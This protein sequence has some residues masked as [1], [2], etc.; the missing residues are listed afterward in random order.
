MDTDDDLFDLEKLRLPEALMVEG[1]AA[2]KARRRRQQFVKF[3]CSWVER[4]QAAR[5]IGSYRLALHLLHRHW[6]ADGKPVRASNVAVAWVGLSRGEK[7][8][9]LEELER[10]G[11]IRVERRPRQAPLVTVLVS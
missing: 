8:R 7:A 11:L 2:A 6:K 1:T 4:L 5:H 10:L 9:A 3:P